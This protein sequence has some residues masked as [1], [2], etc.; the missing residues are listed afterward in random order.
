MVGNV[1]N[2]ELGEKLANGVQTTDGNFTA[3]LLSSSRGGFKSIVREGLPS[4]PRGAVYLK[5]SKN[6]KVDA[7]Q[8]QIEEVEEDEEMTEVVNYF[9]PVSTVRLEVSVGKYR[10]VRRI[11]HNAGHSVIDLKRTRFGKVNLD[12]T[13]K[14]GQ[15]R[16]LQ[17]QEEIDWCLQIFQKI[18]NQERAVALKKRRLRKMAKDPE[19]I[20][21]KAAEAVHEEEEE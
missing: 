5:N 13:L 16:Q 21:K 4:I 18:S 6:K 11:L 19:Q 8:D 10:I 9:G 15:L 17:S 14:S 7:T 1:D 3:K 2:E 20:R 12:E